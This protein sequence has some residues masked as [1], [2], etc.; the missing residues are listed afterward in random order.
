VA[1]ADELNQFG[2]NLS[3]LTYQPATASS[4]PVLWAAL[5]GPGTI[6][7]LLFNGSTWAA[8]TANDWG[9]GKA[10]HYPGGTGNPD[11]E[12]LTRADLGAPFVYV[13]TERNNDS[14]SVSRLAIL[15]FDSSAAGTQLTATHE[16]NLTADLPAVGAN[17][18]L[19]AITWIPDTFLVAN[20]FFDDSRG[21]AYDPALYPNHGNGL[22]V[23]GVEA[24]GALHAYALDHATSAF[25][26][27]ASFASGHA[28]VMGLEFDRDSGGLW[29]ACDNTCAGTQNVL[30][31]VAGKFVVR[32]SYA[33]P[34]TLPDSN[35]EGIGIAPDSECSGG[36][37][38]FFWSDDSHF[39]GH[40]LRVDSI[41]CG[42]LF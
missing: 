30:G 28:G 23:V 27:I 38:R 33:R 19:E 37:K 25:Q 12:S 32:R 13:S 39:A 35:N 6:Y 1:T 8:D 36:F 29:A 34:S 21:A 15:R 16:W 3:G 41:P 14:S 9:A 17:L 11:T 18:G 4:A 40:A 2:D 5:N 24:S 7:R 20:G 31:I 10:L 42:P 22:F 26:K